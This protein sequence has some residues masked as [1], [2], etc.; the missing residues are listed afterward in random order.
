MSKEDLLNQF[1]EDLRSMVGQTIQRKLPD[2]RVIKFV[3]GDITGDGKVDQDDI[4]ILRLLTQGG[5]TAEALFSQL[6]PE[7]IAACDISGDG[8]INREDLIEMCKSV[9]NKAPEKTFNDK[10]SGLRNKIKK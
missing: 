6:S 8:Y 3:V 5:T 7:Q 10:L 1:P 2:G 9:I 4:N